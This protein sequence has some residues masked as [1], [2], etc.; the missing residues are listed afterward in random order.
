MMDPEIGLKQV[1]GKII[2]MFYSPPDM[3]VRSL[4]LLSH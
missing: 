4:E 2:W 3:H 1:Y